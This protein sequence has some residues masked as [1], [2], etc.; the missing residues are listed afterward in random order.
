MIH[1][2]R[3]ISHLS[4]L[5]TA[6]M[7]PASA[8]KTKAQKAAMHQPEKGSSPYPKRH[9]H[10]S[11]PLR[12]TDRSS[13]PDPSSGKISPSVLKARHEGIPQSSTPLSSH[14]KSHTRSHSSTPRSRLF[15]QPNLSILSSFT[16]YNS[17]QF[18]LPKNQLQIPN[19][20]LPF[21][22]VK[23]QATMR[24]SEQKCGVKKNFPD[25]QIF[26]S[27]VVSPSTTHYNSDCQKI[28]FKFQIL[29]FHFPWLRCKRQ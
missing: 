10:S 15:R 7:Q 9:D 24:K 18:G 29:T 17:I 4:H 16:I 20:D 8:P 27:L 14:P 25:H 2:A 26:Q 6:Q 22:M 1:P 23:V 3:P 28:N 12:M 19:T 13:S 5:P 21:S 11:S